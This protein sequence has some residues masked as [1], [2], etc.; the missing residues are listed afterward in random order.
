MM[1]QMFIGGSPGGTAG[2][3]KTVV[4]AV[5]ALAV[6]NTLTGAPHAHAFKRNIPESL[7]RKAATLI[8]LQVATVAV[9]AGML[10]V[11]EH[12]A[13]AMPTTEA[14]V[15]ET[16]SATSTV[17]LS[18]NLTPGLTDPG[19]VVVAL[20][21]FVG[22]VGP[23]AMLASLVVIARRRRGAYEYPTEGVVMS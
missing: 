11:S 21:M 12:R 20:A 2:G 14:L 9:I 1:I 3:V 19:R 18:M 15:F 8:T 4:I 6:W 22:R 23:L 16:I 10:T 5:L 13:D 7:F 17:G